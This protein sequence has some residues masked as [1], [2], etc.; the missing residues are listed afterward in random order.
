MKRKERLANRRSGASRLAITATMVSCLALAVAASTASAATD[1]LIVVQR[2]EIRSFGGF[3]P[4]GSDPS[5]TA[6]NAVFGA[7]TVLR[8]S[9]TGCT[10]EYPVGVTIIFA[11][12]G[13]TGVSACDPSAGKAQ[14]LTAAGFGW[15]TN[16]GLATGDPLKKLI[17]LYDQRRLGP[18]KYDL[19]SK[20]SFIGV[21]G[22]QTVLTAFVSGRRVTALR[23]WAG[24]AGD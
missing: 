23:A 6:A 9:D 1:G 18:G 4:Q 8:D 17:K 3:S 5:I 11:D 12:F 19:V 20:K 21:S 15:Q 10:V 14:Q 13:T 16:R 2:G 24:S 22:R 7:G